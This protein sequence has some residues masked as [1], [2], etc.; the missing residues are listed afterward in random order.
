MK[1]RSQWSQW[2]SGSMDQGEAKLSTHHRDYSILQSLATQTSVYS[3]LHSLRKLQ[4]RVRSVKYTA[5]PEN[6]SCCV[7]GCFAMLVLPLFFEMIVLQTLEVAL[8]SY[9]FMK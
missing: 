8:L 2:D 1:E 5:F 3:R 6:S 4:A 7:K 9:F